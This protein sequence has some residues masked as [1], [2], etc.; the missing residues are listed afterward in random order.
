[1]AIVLSSLKGELDKI[2]EIYYDNDGIFEESESEAI[3]DNIEMSNYLQIE[4]LIEKLNGCGAEFSEVTNMVDQ[5]V[6]RP[7]G[8]SDD[9]AWDKYEILLAQHQSITEQLH[10]VYQKHKECNVI[11]KRYHFNPV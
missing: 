5:E 2:L 4:E 3:S 8:L 1:M 10:A 9:D 7:E 6:E 11:A